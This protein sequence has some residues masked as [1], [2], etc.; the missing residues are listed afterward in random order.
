MGPFLLDSLADLLLTLLDYSKVH[1]S[2]YHPFSQ[3]IL[4]DALEALRCLPS[5]SVEQDLF[6][7]WLLRF[8][9]YCLRRSA[10]AQRAESLGVCPTRPARW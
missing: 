6:V 7:A 5:N 4:G 1:F 2:L 8:F 10:R 9:A 3:L